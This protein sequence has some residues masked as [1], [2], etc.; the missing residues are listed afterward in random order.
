MATN[1]PDIGLCDWCGS[2]DG[3][4]RQIPVTVSREPVQ[5]V[6]MWICD[7]CVNDIGGSQCNTRTR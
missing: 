2:E 6:R 1:D 4:R 3:A 7:E 5:I